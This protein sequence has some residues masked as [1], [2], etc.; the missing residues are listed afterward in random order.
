MKFQ[1]KY[2]QEIKNRIEEPRKFIQAIVGPRQVGK[3]TLV[4]QIIENISIPNLYISADNVPNASNIWIEQQWET[5][6]LKLNSS[7]SNEFLLIIDEIQKI[8]N[9]SETIKQLWDKDSYDNINLKLVIL[10]SSGLLLQQGLQ[11]SLAG[12]FE[13]IKIP[14]W[15]FTEM[16]KC[17]GISA[18]QYA[19]FGAYPGAADII[20]EEKRW[21]EY[22][23]NAIIEA[24]ISKDILMLTR[25]DK[26]ALMRQVLEMGVMY[27][28]KI[29]S[30]NKMIGQLQDAGNT[31]TISHY[32]RL[33]DTAGLLTGITKYYKEE[34]REKASSPKWQCKNSALFAALSSLSYNEIQTDLVKWGQV[35][36]SAIGAHLINMSVNE[37]YNVYFWRHRNDE[38]DFVLQKGDKLI[39]IEVKSGQA[40]ST[41]GMEAF[42]QKFKPYKIFLVGTE[43]LH[44]NE[45]LEI[46][47]STLFV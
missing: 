38:I 22:I 20:D 39:G 14:H 5:A 25:V 15:S 28:S 36:E 27:S 26:P 29:L 11:E 40:K 24:T 23:K 44:W 7:G 30:Y 17:F 32:L 37:D 8:N 21:K 13:L 43:G 47:P 4:K 42:K 16:Q 35:I 19:W 45:F 41:G 9:W 46:S 1:R 3:T 33:L 6:R 31:T 12:R 10:G 18:G 34:Y 2:Y